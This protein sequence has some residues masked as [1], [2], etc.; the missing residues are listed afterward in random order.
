VVVLVALLLVGVFFYRRQTQIF[1]RRQQTRDET[2]TGQK[3]GRVQ[4]WFLYVLAI[5]VTAAFFFV[6]PRVTSFKAQVKPSGSDA[7]AQD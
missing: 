3:I 2:N 1:D 4:M 5:L 7:A 6:V